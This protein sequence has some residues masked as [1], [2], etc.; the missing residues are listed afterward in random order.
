MIAPTV[1]MFVLFAINLAGFSGLIAII[2]M[3]KI[4]VHRELKRIADATAH[5]E[6]LLS[7][8]L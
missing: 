8:R 1:L 4:N 2:F 5:V 7:K 6:A 3:A